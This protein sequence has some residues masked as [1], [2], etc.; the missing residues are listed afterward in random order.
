MPKE[1]W[2]VGGSP[3]RQFPWLDRPRYNRI[4][5]KTPSYPPNQFASCL[6]SSSLLFNHLLCSDCSA[7]V[8]CNARVFED[9]CGG[10]VS[11]GLLSTLSS[12]SQNYIEQKFSI[13]A[14]PQPIF[15][16]FDSF[17]FPCQPGGVAIPKALKCLNSL[18]VLQF[19]G[20]P[21]DTDMFGWLTDCLQ[22]YEMKTGGIPVDWWELCKQNDN[23][24]HLGRHIGKITGHLKVAGPS[25]Q[26]DGAMQLSHTLILFLK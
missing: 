25:C 9:A 16:S 21:P 7:S 5:T 23:I 26:R 6:P 15:L 3:R 14:S 19:L 11:S 1:T 8:V 20:V 12:S 13:S 18:L 24:L 22:W 10:H 17:R 2:R 4:S